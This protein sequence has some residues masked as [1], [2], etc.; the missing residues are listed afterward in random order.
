MH[1]V[2]RKVFLILNCILAESFDGGEFGYR[3]IGIFVPVN[4]INKVH[5]GV[6]DNLFGE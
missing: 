6:C 2:P 5:M 3:L 1:I 4:E